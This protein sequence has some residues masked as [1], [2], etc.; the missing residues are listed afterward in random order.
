MAIDRTEQLIVDLA[1]DL[2][3]ARR[4]ASMSVRMMRWLA[5]AALV[6]AVAVAVIG[7]RADVRR[8]LAESGVLLSLGL[9]LMA[10]T[11][12]AAVAVRLSV[13]GADASRWLR[14]LP[15]LVMAAWVALLVGMSRSTGVL[16]AALLHEPFHA[17]CVVRVAAIAILPALLL[18]REVRRG[19]A[20][21]AVPAAALTALGGSALAALAVQLVCPVNRP[22]HVLVSHVLPA[23]GLVVAAAVAASVYPRAIRGHATFLK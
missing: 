4:L 5:T 8:A 2:R 3:P 16:P 6:A 18:M 19:F 23:L 17:P 12:A 20:L 22:E 7:L 11:S 15:L 9:A 21:D 13:P 10:S 14:W 1:G